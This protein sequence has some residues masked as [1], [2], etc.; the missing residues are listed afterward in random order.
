MQEVIFYISSLGMLVLC[1]VIAGLC[2][3]HLGNCHKHDYKDRL[4]Y[5]AVLTMAVV[6][7]AQPYYVHYFPNVGGLLLALSMVLFM[8]ANEMV[9][10]GCSK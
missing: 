9:W 10:R 3:C 2:V 7:A 5:T 1:L 6:A 8:G 4:I